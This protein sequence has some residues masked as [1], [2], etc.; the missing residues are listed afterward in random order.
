MGGGSSQTVVY[1][2]KNDDFVRY[3]DFP[4]TCNVPRMLVIH[5]KVYV[6]GGCQGKGIFQLA[7]NG[8]WRKSAINTDGIS[9]YM[10]VTVGRDEIGDI[11]CN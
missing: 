4:T 2:A 5:G 7:K 1:H 8:G 6:V 9:T 10:A 11:K 3:P